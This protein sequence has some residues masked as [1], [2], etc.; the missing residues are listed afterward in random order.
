[1]ALALGCRQGEALGLKWDRL[2]RV[3]KVLRIR[4]G[5]QRQKWLHGCSD[6]VEC[7]A[8]HHRVACEDPCKR[9]RS[10][11]KY[12]KDEKG[13]SRPC[14]QGCVKHAVLCPQRH[15]GGLVEVDV[16]SRAGRRSLVLPDELYDLLM[17]HEAAQ[18]AERAHA[19]SEWQEGGWIFAQPNGRPIGS[20]QDWA[21]WKSI[22]SAAG[23][24]DARLHDARHTAATVLLLG[25]HPRAAME[26]MGWSTQAM[27]QRYMHV[28]D[29]LR[30]DVADQLN[31]HFWKLN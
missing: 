5:L 27:Q 6:P 7:T 28:T 19:G 3:N 29:Q 15:G 12:V 9:H 4:K 13:H 20:R 30:K 14:P 22:L 10:P 17:R 24:R 1:M 11:K 26:L 21:E 31:A 2:D 23:V 16:K 8:G 25:V 18:A